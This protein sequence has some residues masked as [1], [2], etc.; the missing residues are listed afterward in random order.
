MTELPYNFTDKKGAKQT[1]K[2]IMEVA[3]CQ[4]GRLNIEKLIKLPQYIIRGGDKKMS[5]E[6]EFNP[7][8]L[9]RGS[10]PQTIIGSRAEEYG[11]AYARSRWIRSSAFIFE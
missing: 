5:E 3:L 4:T 8:P 11:G 9:I 6:L 10:K 7:L 1:I 2:E